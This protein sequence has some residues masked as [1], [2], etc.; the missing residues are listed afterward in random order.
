MISAMRR[1]VYGCLS[2]CFDY[3]SRVLVE[4]EAAE[5]ISETFG[6]LARYELESLAP[7]VDNFR[8]A[9]S[10]GEKSDAVRLVE[11]EVEYS[12]LFVGPYKP[13]V[14]PCES[15]FL[16]A[17]RR[18]ATG[19][20]YLVEAYRQEGLGLTS[21]FKELPD[22]ISAEF[23]FMAHLCSKEIE[24]DEAGRWQSAFNY[25]D[26]QE[27]FIKEHIIVWVPAFLQIIER[28]TTSDFYKSLARI[29]W[30]FIRWDYE[31]LSEVKSES[32]KLCQS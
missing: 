22:H 6:A 17:Y 2:L 31:R 25:E 29:A 1:N 10:N 27:A 21:D 14:Y 16:E 30:Q 4:A 24:A 28:A 20:Q 26:K 18:G 8:F 23:E 32:V 19:G 9:L 12:R 13:L 7:E 15:I 5:I 11:L 3:P